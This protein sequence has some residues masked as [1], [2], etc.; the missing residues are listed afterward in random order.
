RRRRRC[1][2]SPPLR[3]FPE[4]VPS[5][6]PKP[7]AP[8]LPGAHLVPTPGVHSAAD[9]GARL[10]A[11]LESTSPPTSEP[12]S[13]PLW[14]PPRRRPEPTPPS[15]RV[16]FPVEQFPRSICNVK[17]LLMRDYKLMTAS[18]VTD[19]L[20]LFCSGDR[21]V[22]V[23]CMKRIVTIP[24]PNQAA[25][26]CKQPGNSGHRGVAMVPPSLLEPIGSSLQIVVLLAEAIL[27]RHHKHGL[28]KENCKYH[29]RL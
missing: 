8:P 25:G 15:S 26:K 29:T 11:A 2:R 5:S 28:W 16:S 4:P 17:N 19:R 10:A 23:C 9:L 18:A 13:L 22:R 21:C 14:S 27:D 3:H 20:I 24:F 7:A 1:P 12:A 6:P